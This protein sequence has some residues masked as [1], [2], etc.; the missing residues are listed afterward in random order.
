MQDKQAIEILL[1]LIEK[2]SL[3]A[4][5]KEAVRTAIGILSWTKLGQARIKNLGKVRKAKQEQ[6]FRGNDLLK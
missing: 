3:S 5:E 1:R 4:E 6:G 2:D